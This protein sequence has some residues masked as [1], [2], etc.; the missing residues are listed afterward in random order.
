[1][2]S[3]LNLSAREFIDKKL[4][5]KRKEAIQDQLQ[6]DPSSINRI[7]QEYEKVNED[8]YYMWVTSSPDDL[9]PLSTKYVRS[10]SLLGIYKVGKKSNYKHT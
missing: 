1:M 3:V 8:D 9:Y 7:D 10:D 4:F 2:K 5:F 6:Q